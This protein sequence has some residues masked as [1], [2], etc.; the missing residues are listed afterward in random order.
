MWRDHKNQHK[1]ISAPR[2]G[3]HW[4][5]AEHWA[6]TLFPPFVQTPALCFPHPIAGCAHVLAA[7]ALLLAAPS[8][9]KQLFPLYHLPV[10]DCFTLSCCA[11][12]KVSHKAR[13]KRAHA[14]TLPLEEDR[15]VPSCIHEGHFPMPTSKSAWS[16][17]TSYSPP[18]PDHTKVSVA[19]CTHKHLVSPHQGER[20]I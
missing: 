9:C 15:T 5:N 11:L 6:L 12:K 2:Q 1:C 14:V 19:T 20:V 13:V 7:I 18:S 8:S 17:P 3:R 16:H 10:L 4:A